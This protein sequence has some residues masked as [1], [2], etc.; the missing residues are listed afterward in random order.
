MVDKDFYSCDEEIIG[1]KSQ[2]STNPCVRGRAILE[3]CNAAQLRILNGR[4]V[5]D[6]LANLLVTNITVQV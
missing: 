3:L 4:T 2:D 6:I 5:G 1:R